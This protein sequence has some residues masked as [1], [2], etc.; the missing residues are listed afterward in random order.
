MSQSGVSTTPSRPRAFVLSTGSEITQGVYADT[1]AMNLSRF[2]RDHGFRVVGHAAAPD[3]THRIASA[4][5]AASRDSDLIVMTGGLGP[6]EDDLTRNAVCEVWG[7]RLHHVRRAEV[8]MRQR[9]AGRGRVMPERNVCQADIPEGAIALLNH[10]GTA[11]GFLIPPDGEHPAFLALPGVPR[12]W[13]AMMERHFARHVLPFFPERP[14]FERLIIH[15][16]QVPESEINERLKELFDADPEVEIGLLAQMGI[17]RV[18]ITVT[19]GDTGICRKKLDDFRRRVRAALPA[20][21][22][23]GETG[24]LLLPEA[25]LVPQFGEAG[26]TIAL[27]ESCTGGGVAKRITDV[28][29]S[30]EVLLAGWVT[31]SNAAKENCLG[32]NRE[33]LERHGAVS[34]ACVRE[35]AIGARQASGADVALAVSGIAGPGGGTPEKPVG[36]VWF[37]MA[38]ADGSAHAFSQRFSGDRSDV[39]HLACNVALDALRRW[40]SGLPPV[41]SRVPGKPRNG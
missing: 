14:V 16:A 1:N 11:P 28:P 18:R 6:T 7:R 35:M 33:T 36:L 40:L 26:K 12:E 3:E 20:D 34:E 41:P 9:F 27:A 30:S 23:F 25:A 13:R 22:I 24:D 31:Y 10:W 4:I 38:D 37:G 5:R 2:L 17:I 19:A 32:V 15:L 8:M 39:R 29:G 21:V